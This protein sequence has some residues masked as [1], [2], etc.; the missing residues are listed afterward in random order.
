MK[1]CVPSMENNE[2]NKSICCF[3]DQVSDDNF[4]DLRK[5]KL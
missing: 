4:I 1:K 3:A 5:N 2:P